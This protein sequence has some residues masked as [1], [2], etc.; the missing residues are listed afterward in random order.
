MKMRYLMAA[1]VT[2]MAGMGSVASA[3]S[4]TTTA[5]ITGLNAGSAMNGTA[6][7]TLNDNGHLTI[8]LTNNVAN[9][10]T[11]AS[12]LDGITFTL[13]GS[14][15]NNVVP[16][17]FSV[18]GELID[19]NLTTNTWSDATPAQ[20]SAMGANANWTESKG[21]PF[22]LKAA[23]GKDGLIIGAPGANG[24]YSNADASLGPKEQPFFKQTVEFNMDIAGLTSATTLSNVNFLWGTGSTS[25]GATSMTTTASGGGSVVAAPLPGAVWGGAALMVGMVVVRGIRRRM[26]G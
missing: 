5:L 22:T 13:A 3:N 2:A 8:D 12:L 21:D 9:P 7:F 10:V 25:Y 14:A 15:F 23:N 6:V 11:A 24:L 26:A 17:N 16:T 19:V 18:S 1:M 20:I 4:V